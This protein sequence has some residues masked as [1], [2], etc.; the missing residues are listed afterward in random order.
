MKR[1]YGGLRE[2]ARLAAMGVSGGYAIGRGIMYARNR[3]NSMRSGSSTSTAASTASRRRRVVVRSTRNSAVIRNLDRN[4]HAPVS[5]SRFK[6]Y[7][8]PSKV[9]RMVRNLT[10][11]YTLTDHFN[12]V[13]TNQPG[14]QQ[15]WQYSHLN[16]VELLQF[17]DRL[18]QLI[19]HPATG[20]ASIGGMIA[21]ER[22][23]TYN[24]NMQFLNS[25]NHPVKI[26]LY[27]VCSKYD[28]YDPMQ[29]TGPPA[30]QG[31]PLLTWRGDVT[32]AFQD[33]ILHKESSSEYQAGLN[34]VGQ[35][36]S[37]NNQ[38]Y[39]FTHRDYDCNLE[40]S[41]LFRDYFRVKKK[42][43]KVLQPNETHIHN[44][45][46][47]LNMM[48][49]NVKMRNVAQNQPG[50]APPV[51]QAP[52]SL[53]NLTIF[54]F[55][56]VRG[57]I[58]PSATGSTTTTTGGRLDILG[59]IKKTGSVIQQI[60]ATRSALAVLPYASNTQ[61]INPYSGMPQVHTK[62]STLYEPLQP[63][64][65]ED[66]ER[67]EEMRPGYEADYVAPASEEAVPPSSLVPERDLDT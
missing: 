25:S 8:K 3:L 47:K 7:R 23:G 54:T 34:V 16:Y 67:F 2:A 13:I 26:T 37:A 56:V 9:T 63:N 6:L 29:Y 27:E 36:P 31:V 44:V 62:V 48:L 38:G 50:G 12:D 52:V 51:V 11:P 30:P 24:N 42:I 10:Q 64:P 58:A 41:A 66:Q 32:S 40:G 19:T 55:I 53:A 35:V 33:G 22:F 21:R 17:R 61:Y 14:L 5:F 28:T 60:Q 1:P 65:G 49:D 45:N 4:P 18:R 57:L 39:Q 20:S 46:I 43:T 59:T 15:T